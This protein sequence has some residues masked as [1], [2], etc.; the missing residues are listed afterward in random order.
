VSD[1]GRPGHHLTEVAL[2]FLI[3]GTFAFGGPA[4]HVALMRR[5][6]VVRRK[7]LPEDEFKRMFAACNLIPGSSSTELAIFLG[8]RRAGWRG[9]LIGGVLFI[10]PAMLMMLGIAWL[11]VRYSSS[12]LAG[13]VLFGVRAAVTGIVAWAILDLGRRFLSR[14]ILLGLA[15]A[16]ALLSVLGINPVFLIVAAGLAVAFGGQLLRNRGISALLLAG[17]LMPS[18]RLL[19]VFLTFLKL[20]AFSFGSG[21]VLYAF[22]HADFVLG[23]HWLT[24]QQLVDAVAIGQATPGPVFTT[25]TFLGYLFAGVPGA[26]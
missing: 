20:G 13:G 1:A 11:Y 3:L 10:L 21:Y 26:C 9:L 16:I 4:A 24:E 15:A 22:L 8:Y 5:E 2:A 12:H 19:A 7:W 6:L 23:L 18:G 25:A 14:W 17:G